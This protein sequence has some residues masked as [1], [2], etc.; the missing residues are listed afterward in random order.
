LTGK[1]NFFTSAQAQIRTAAGNTM[2]YSH[3]KPT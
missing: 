3:A 2:A 1:S